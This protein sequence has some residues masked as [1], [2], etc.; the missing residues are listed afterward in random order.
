MA[1]SAG[2]FTRFFKPNATVKGWCLTGFWDFDAAAGSPPTSMTAYNFIDGHNLIFDDQKYKDQFT[3]VP[4][5]F[6]QNVSTGAIPLK[7]VTPMQNTKYKVFVQPKTVGTVYGQ[8]VATDSTNPRAL[9]GYC[10]NS[11][12]YPKTKD[13][14][15]I[16]F[17]FHLNNTDTWYS[18]AGNSIVNGPGLGGTLNRVDAEAFIQLQVV[19]L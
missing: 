8:A 19:V 9:F 10:L 14:F 11:A 15:W 2:L 4:S 1:N 13:G 7:F 18:A 16:R 12:Q 3:R 5:T 17:G 6:Q